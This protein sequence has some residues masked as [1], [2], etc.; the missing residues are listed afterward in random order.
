MMPALRLAA[1]DLLVEARA[2]ESF[3][4]MLVLAL[5]VATVGLLAFRD[6][7]DAPA[8]AAGVLWAGLAFAA[9]LGYARSFLAERDR[10]TWDALLALP[11]ERG[12]IYSGKVL[13]N[14]AV[15]L[16]VAALALPAYLFLAGHAV[17][18]AGALIV[19]LAVALGALGLAASGT[20]LAAL[21]AATRARE[22][23]LPVLLVPVVLPV[24]I[25]GVGVTRAALAGEG[26]PAVQGGILLLAGYDLAFL[27]ASWLL[28][29][30]V[31][32]SS[33]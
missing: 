2:K 27:A 29:D 13:V 9:S 17:G 32:E 15:T 10:G 31:A 14:Y 8:V 23:L 33:T 21:A 26:W 11:V 4:A 3:T 12:T 7:A 18:L 20:I 24:L 16:V 5:L 6:A 1:K 19:A 28:F 30:V 22:T 25:A